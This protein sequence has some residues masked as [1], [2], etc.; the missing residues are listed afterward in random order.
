MMDLY[1]SGRF[2]MAESEP[3]LRARVATEPD[4]GG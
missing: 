2:R 1:E 3:R 4:L